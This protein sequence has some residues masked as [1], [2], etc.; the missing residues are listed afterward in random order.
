M[1]HPKKK[2]SM[3]EI[4]QDQLVTAYV[5]VT[6]FYEANKKFISYGTTALILIII[7]IVIYANNRRAN[8]E[9]A[10]TELGKVYAIYDAATGDIAQYKLA[11][12]GQPERG[13]MGL[14]AI[15]DNYGGTTSGQLA[16]FYLATAY[17]NLGNYD[18]ALKHFEDY[19][20]ESDL[21]NA[22]AM[23][24]I[25]KCLEAKGEYLKAAG[26]FENAAHIVSNET[27]TPD[28]LNSAAKCYGMG[29]EKEKAISL[30]K[31]IKKEYPRTQFA[32]D[33]DRYIS[34]FSA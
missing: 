12:D 16:R 33:A 20:G 4:K 18:E 30:L 15:V 28:Y 32:R 6:S 27:N 25:G 24:G 19:D 14:K 10:A 23:A 8:D 34:Q 2:I 7:G 1:L 29:G 17:Y 31:R 5:K 22:A 11:I 26:K 13:I 21:L 9:K 3:K